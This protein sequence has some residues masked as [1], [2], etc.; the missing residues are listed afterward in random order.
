[1]SYKTLSQHLQNEGHRHPPEKPETM[2]ICTHGRAEGYEEGTW[3]RHSEATGAPASD[4]RTTRVHE[5]KGKGGT[6]STLSRLVPLAVEADVRTY[7][8]VPDRPSVVIVS[9]MR[10]DTRWTPPPGHQ[11]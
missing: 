10:A 8:E 11:G 9:Y 4:R 1:M 6:R 3:H 7:D 5:G 2:R